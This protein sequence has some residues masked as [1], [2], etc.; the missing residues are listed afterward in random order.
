MNV[1]D[2]IGPYAYSLLHAHNMLRELMLLPSELRDARAGAAELG[3]RFSFL[4]DYEGAATVMH[5]RLRA[6]YD[7]Y[8]TTVSPPSITISRRL[9]TFLGV[10]CEGLRPTQILDLGSGFSSY[11]LGMYAREAGR[12]VGVRSVDLSKRWL[13][14]TQRFLD[15]QHVDRVS[16]C[17]LDEFRASPT[18]PAEL[19]L[20]DIGELPQRL[21]L[22]DLTLQSC[23][24]GGVIVIDDMH[25]PRYRQAMRGLL[26]ERGLVHFS[27]RAWTRNRLRYAY[28]VI[29]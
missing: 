15:A 16:L 10:V 8:T 28:L 27:L 2:R 17:T 29:R 5:E 7:D 22:L 25:V 23:A 26:R 20:L 4:R 12:S 24:P 14:A 9:A 6:A 18:P 11:V 1:L 19:V 13:D 3:T 21:Q